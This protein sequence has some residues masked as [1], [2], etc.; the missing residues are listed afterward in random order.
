LYA[1]TDYRLNDF[2]KVIEFYP[3]DT[4]A[5]SGEA[6]PLIHSIDHVPC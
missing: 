4:C 3:V 1:L 2:G 6:A 5:R